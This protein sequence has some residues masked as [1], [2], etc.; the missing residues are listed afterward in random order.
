MELIVNDKEKTTNHHAPARRFLFLTSGGRQGG[1]T[2]Q[3]A[4]IAASSLAK[5]FVQDWQTLDIAEL[6]PFHD[7]RHSG[8]GVY[9]APDA[10]LAELL[11]ATL[12]ATD[13]V[14]V[15]PL[16]WYNMSSAAKLYFEHWSAWMRVPGLDFLAR[17]QGKRFYVISTAADEDK[18]MFDALIVA[19]R[20]TAEYAGM[21]WGGSLL[22]YANRP[23][24]I[25]QDQATLRLAQTFLQAE[26]SQAA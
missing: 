24:D 23:G 5:H 16:Y 13:L 2:E 22:G 18:A 12:A 3:L 10:R 11:A 6:A 1:N 4:R 25:L 20:R 17:M 15:T 19:S 26:Q 7:L 9:A 8:D 21:E 14:L